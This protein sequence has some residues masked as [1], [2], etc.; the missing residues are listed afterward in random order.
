MKRSDLGPLWSSAIT[1][2][3]LLVYIP[4]V[5]YPT[6]TGFS[7]LTE[8]D[9]VFFS[10][11]A[12]FLKATVAVYLL[13]SILLRGRRLKAVASFDI[14]VGML[15]LE[16][17][18]IFAFSK[19]SFA[20]IPL[21][22]FMLVYLFFRVAIGIHGPRPLLISVFMYHMALI[23]GGLALLAF[24]NDVVYQCLLTCD[25]RLFKGLYGGKNSLGV[26]SALCLFIIFLMS[27]QLQLK[28]QYLILAG[29]LSLCSLYFSMS[30]SPAFAL[31]A[32]LTAYSIKSADKRA[33]NAIAIS[34]LF[35]TPLSFIYGSTIA[36]YLLEAV[37]RDFSLTG[38][39]EIWAMVLS[40]FDIQLIGGTGYGSSISSDV[41]FRYD[42]TAID[43]AWIILIVEH[44]AMFGIAYL[45][46]LIMNVAAPVGK[47]A[48]DKSTVVA[49]AVFLL[50]Y[51]AVE[52]GAGPYVGAPF[53]M[54]LL[55]YWGARSAKQAR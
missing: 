2:V 48:E 8:A 18:I 17:V 9:G 29:T 30:L 44:G 42:I 41:A 22:N 28:R 6:Y 27:K 33:Y 47:T 39:T 11:A 25:N 1:V 55:V 36:F 21:A 15:L 45:A 43:S 19:G 52:K 13:G 10:A 24:G 32:A 38:R 5:L 14:I 50:F 4:P 49:I 35:L 54:L 20:L 37:G 3:L 23:A 34:F 16:N 53:V 51:G 12:P 7:D 46:W 26:S 40:G 31:V